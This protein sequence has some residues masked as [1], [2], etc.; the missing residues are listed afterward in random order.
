MDPMEFKHEDS[1]YMTNDP[2]T[3]ESS[4][5]S[6]PSK[7]KHKFSKKQLA[8]LGLASVGAASAL[9]GGAYYLYKKNKKKAKK[10]EE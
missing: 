4:S 10:T 3:S 6:E 8:A 2:E 5:V 9:G 7:K 1:P